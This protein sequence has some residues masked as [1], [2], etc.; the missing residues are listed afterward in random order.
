VSKFLILSGISF[1][2]LSFNTIL[3]DSRTNLR[4]HSWSSRE[5]SNSIFEIDRRYVDKM[6]RQDPP[7]WSSTV[8]L[9]N[10]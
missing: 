5:F 7:T 8:K 3:N 10:K 1:E 6:L 9:Q 2:L 4:R